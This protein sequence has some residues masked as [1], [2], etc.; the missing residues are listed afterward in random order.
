MSAGQ[1]ARQEHGG[2]NLSAWALTHKPL[3]GFLM[4]IALLAGLRAYQ[5][6]GRDEDPPFTIKTMV[7]RAFW[8][9]AD[10][11]Q[12]AKQLTDRLEKPL[13]SLEYI[14]FV[15]SYTK[16]GEA[17]IM[18][19]LRD[20][21]P[22]KA[23][24]DQWYQVRKKL[25]DIRG[26]LAAGRRRSV[27]QRRLRRRV[28]RDLRA[29]QRRLHLSRAARPGRVHP[30][31]AAAREQR[32]QGGSHRRAGRGHLHRPV[33]AADGG[34]GHRAGTAGRDARQ[35]ERRHCLRH[36]RNAE[37]THRRAREWRARFGRGARKRR[38]SRRRPAGAPAG[39]RARDAR[40]QGSAHAAVP[41]Q[42]HA[43]DRH[44]RVHVEGR[45]RARS[46]RGARKGA[47]AHRERSA[48]GHRRASR[49]QPARG[50]RGIRRAVH[51]RIVRGHRHRADRELREPGRARRPGG[52]DQHSAGARDHLRVHG[53]VRDQ[54]AAHL[55]RRVDH[56]ARPAGGR[57]HDRGGDDGE[58]N[59]GGLG[60]VP[61]RHLRLHLHR[62]PDAHRHAGVGRGFP[63]GGIRQE[64]RR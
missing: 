26:Q 16:P 12:T 62:I 17:T 30:R 54:P 61:R 53:H 11:I 51:A 36:H 52:R 5:G 27:L 31:R 8:P 64:R 43:R 24:P 56:L 38:H 41:L 39:F 14:D 35:P 46:R 34:L 48:G 21:T 33:A 7:V 13:E 59:G 42:R 18:V 20:S 3:I 25:G 1:G 49:R 29:D 23:V 44:R 40:L 45:Q 63:A 6:L 28:W 50:G 22:P 47:H 60:Q 9:G 2:F 55:A 37:R 32:R 58:E 19:N 4:V 15:T 10:A 57:R